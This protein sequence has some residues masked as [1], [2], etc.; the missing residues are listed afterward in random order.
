MSKNESLLKKE[1]KES[2]VQRVRNLV[3][4]DFTAST[5]QQ[6]G[7]QRSTKRHKE[8]EIWDEDGKTWTVKNGIK[9]NITKLD[10]AKKS[11]RTPLRCPKCSG[12]LKHHLAKKMYKVHGFCFNCTI[13]ME[14]G[15]RKAGLYETY[16]K[17]MM[18]GNIKGFMKD[19][20]AWVLESI[21][22]N[23][24]FVTE[25]G[26]VEDWGGVGQGFKQQILKDLKG[27]T[28]LLKK[29]VE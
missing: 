16:E 17:R 15:L 26:V 25:D 5:K 22:T 27:Y 29:H 4:K 9:Q 8:G 18:Q 24:S 11:I 2:D 13:D 21:N 12:S 3:N 14:A 23:E 10:S 6:V 7:Y 28:D 1:F 20:E 19:I